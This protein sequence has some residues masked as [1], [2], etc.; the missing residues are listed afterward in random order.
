MF[1][2]HEGHDSADP[3][4][5]VGAG[6]NVQEGPRSQTHLDLVPTAVTLTLTLESAGEGRGRLVGHHSADWDRGAE[7]FGV[8]DSEIGARAFYHFRQD[9]SGYLEDVKGPVSV[10]FDEGIVNACNGKKQPYV[11]IRSRIPATTFKYKLSKGNRSQRFIPRSSK[12]EDRR[13]MFTTNEKPNMMFI[14]MET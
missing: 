1:P 2:S 14:P 11:S 10:A 8:Q 7:D 4:V 13:E 6:A 9:E 3:V 5:V 12:V